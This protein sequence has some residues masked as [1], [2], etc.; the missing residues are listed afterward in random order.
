MQLFTR[1]MPSRPSR[2][3]LAMS[4]PPD[5]KRPVGACALRGFTLIEL[6]VVIAIIAILAAM[7]LPALTKA[8]EQGQGAK[9]ESNGHQMILA[10]TMYASENRE[11]LPNNIPSANGNSGGW[12]NGVLS[13]EVG[14]SDNTNYLAMMGGAAGSDPATHEP[15]HASTATIGPYTK[16]PGIYQCPAD[17]ITA[18]GYGVQRV[19]SYSMDFTCGSKATNNPEDASYDDYW[20]NFFKSSDFR[21]ASKT[22]VFSDEH[23]DSINDGIQ[24]TPTSD[25]EDDQWS[26]LPASY[27]NGAAGYAFA[28]GHSEI[29][30]WLNPNTAHVIEGNGDWLPLT[31]VGSKVDID[32][33]ES[34]ASPRADGVANQAPGP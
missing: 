15:Y 9:C 2:A 10:W 25:G 5:S 13:E 27:H 7:L 1:I 29:H 14:N 22:W 20:P 16:S 24:F 23:P 18:P 34:H 17:P 30:K 32:W 19:R 28:D 21:I 6:L 3:H 33:V 4:T 8:K 31:V 11:V 26:D 12:V